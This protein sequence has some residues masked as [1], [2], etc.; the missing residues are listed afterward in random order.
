MRWFM[1]GLRLVT[2][3]GVRL[4]VLIPL[5]CNLVLFAALFAA[6][7]LWFDHLLDWLDGLL[8]DWLR[9]LRW[10]LWPLL[11]VSALILLG[12]SFSAVANIVAS[13]FNSLLSEQVQRVLTGDQLASV[14]F[15]ELLM[16]DL[17]RALARQLQFVL[18]WAPRS[19]GVLVLFVIPG[20]QIVAPALWFLFN[21][22]MMALQYLDY[23]MDN[24]RL[25]FRRLV[26]EARR[27]RPRALEFGAV[28][29][30]AMMIPGINVLAMQ[31]AVAGATA[32]WVAEIA[33]SL[34][35]RPAERGT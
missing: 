10:V 3:P 34:E 15:R 24:N 6:G 16:R 1:L 8:P 22:W 23:P 7:I 25:P 26:E 12:T 14:T 18:Y 28:V 35:D 11:V 2:R 29:A 21:A 4:Y 32:L 17:P 9:W 20:V 19:L 27:L 5:T 13:P 30:I 31:V 33:P